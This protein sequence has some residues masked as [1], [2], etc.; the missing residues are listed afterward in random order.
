M[1]D[2]CDKPVRGGSVTAKPS[3]STDSAL[4]DSALRLGHVRRSLLRSRRQPLRLHADRGIR[5]DGRA[6]A[7]GPD[8]PG[9]RDHRRRAAGGEH[10]GGV[11]LWDAGNGIVADALDYNRLHGIDSSYTSRARVARIPLA[12]HLDRFY[13]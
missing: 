1:R 4:R 12:P 3:M 11:G 6:V 8:H 2:L 9:C 13:I 7:G 5:I 10:S